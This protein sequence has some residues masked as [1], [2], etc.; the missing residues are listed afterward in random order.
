MS[1]GTFEPGVSIGVFVGANIGA[2]DGVLGVERNGDFVAVTV[3][4]RKTDGDCE[5]V[6]VVGAFEADSA[7]D[8]VAEGGGQK[9]T[10]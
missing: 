8:S 1:V 3:G 5:L 9:V 2:L 7:G 4:P 10:R 6:V